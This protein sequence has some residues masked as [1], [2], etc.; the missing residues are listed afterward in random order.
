MRKLYILLILVLGPLVTVLAQPT[1]LVG[2]NGNACND[3]V[4]D[5]FCVP[6]TSQDFTNINSLEFDFGYD[7]AVLNF[8]GAQN[9]HP[10]M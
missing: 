2:N 1:I 10:D 9:F 4:N 6:V 5:A 7:P 8:T 3:G